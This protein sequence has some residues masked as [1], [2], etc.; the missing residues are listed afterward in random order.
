MLEGSL[1]PFHPKPGEMTA[2][3]H[4]EGYSASAMDV[5]ARVFIRHQVERAFLRFG[6]LGGMLGAGQIWRQFR[7]GDMTHHPEEGH[8]K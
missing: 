4:S 2:M 6:A 3:I 1:R 5:F 8:T 7:L